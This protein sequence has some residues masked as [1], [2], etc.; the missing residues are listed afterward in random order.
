M[1]KIFRTDYFADDQA[2][3]DGTPPA[4]GAGLSI[5]ADAF[6]ARVFAGGYAVELTTG[7]HAN[8]TYSVNSDTYWD[9][10]QGGR[11]TPVVVASG[12][13]EPAVTAL[14]KRVYRV[15]TDGADRTTLVDRRRVHVAVTEMVDISGR[16]RMT[17]EGV[18]VNLG[19]GSTLGERLGTQVQFFLD[20]NSGAVY[21]SLPSIE[22]NGALGPIRIYARM[23]GAGESPG[24]TFVWGAYLTGATTWTI[25]STEAYRL[26]LAP[27]GSNAG[28][29]FARMTGLTPAGTFADSAWLSALAANTT[30][31]Q[32][33]IGAGLK[34]GGSPF[35]QEDDADANLTA[36]IEYVR[37]AGGA[38]RTLLSADLP[39]GLESIVEYSGN[40]SSL[41]TYERVF[42]ATWDDAAAQWNRTIAGDAWR[43]YL[44]PGGFRVYRRNAA[45]ASPWVTSS[46]TLAFSVN[47]ATVDIEQLLYV[48]G[49]A[50]FDGVITANAGITNTLID[51][52]PLPNQVT[53]HGIRASG[54]IQ[55]TGGS[56]GTLAL[57]ATGEGYTAAINGGN[58]RITVTNAI[59]AGFSI[60]FGVF[61]TG[62]TLYRP[63][64]SQVSSTQVDVYVHNEAG[65][66]HD[67]DVNVFRF[68]FMITGRN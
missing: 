15:R 25:V 67:I 38:T 41:N 42:N 2:L 45:S 23:T 66:A 36:L 47:N 68:C 31:M 63:H 40:E 17:P 61:E 20:Q 64:Y 9:L 43:L 59:V 26:D 49:A 5:L 16:M 52:S 1:S 51:V 24:L 39:A 29:R 54:E 30:R 35:G 7:P 33:P 14:S 21:Q 11:W 18:S 50:T 60:T 19:N 8:Y 28:M 48:L 65:A 57:G 44:A 10:S 62:S 53:A 3:P 13:G 6:S 55:T 22:S 32:L 34:L 37:N 12:A 56:A 58:V 46:W 27:T 4:I